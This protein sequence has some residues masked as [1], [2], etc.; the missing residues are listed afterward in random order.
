MVN[1][2]SRKL[3]C[4][5][6][7]PEHIYGAI[8]MRLTKKKLVE[9]GACSSGLD[10]YCKN[11]EPET[12]KATIK[13]LLA[14][15]KQERFNWS[16]WFFGKVFTRE[17]AVKYAIFSARLVLHIYEEK[18]P[19]D[20]R[21]RLAIEAAETYLKNPLEETQRAAAAAA[22]AATWATWAAARAA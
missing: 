3:Q 12:V 15:S 22:A 17:Q 9:M 6:V 10:W 18:Y 16:N 19:N 8:N 7:T 13:K 14:S 21:P 1:D 11:G 4:P 20:N 2:K 5:S